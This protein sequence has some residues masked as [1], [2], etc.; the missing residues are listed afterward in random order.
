SLLIGLVEQML[1]RREDWLGLV[2]EL[3]G[4]A[5]LAD[6]RGRLEQA[7]ASLVRSQLEALRQSFPTAALHEA[8]ELAHLRDRAALAPTQGGAA[9]ALRFLHDDSAPTTALDQRERWQALA[10]L[11]LTKEGRWLK[12]F[13]PAI[14]HRARQL[15]GDLEREPELRER[16]HTVRSLPPERFSEDEWRVLAAIIELLPLAAAELQVVFGETGRADYAS[17]AAAARQALGTDD[18]PT[19]LAVTLDAELRHV[20]VDEFQDTSHAQVRLLER[21]TADW[22]PGDGR[23]LFVVGDPMQSIYRFRNA[24]VGHFI[25]ARERGIGRVRLEPLV[26]AVNFRSSQPVIDWNN[27]TFAEVLPRIDDTTAGAVRFAP[28]IAAPGA[29]A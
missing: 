14:G 6:I 10:G 5:T 20:L 13:P 8:A 12:K 26:L 18:Q 21:L 22:S 29:A 11:L 4:G 27:A 7:R 25:A 17:F 16:L 23:T 15:A 19:D 3:R 9:A 2:Q 28:S 24:E 1:P